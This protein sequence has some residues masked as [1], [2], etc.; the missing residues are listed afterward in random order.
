ME[1]VEEY[2]WSTAIKADKEIGTSKVVNSKP[3]KDFD[4]ET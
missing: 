2:I 4:D 1:K 3:L